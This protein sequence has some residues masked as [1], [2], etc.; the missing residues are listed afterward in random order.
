MKNKLYVLAA[1]AVSLLCTGCAET[2]IDQSD[3]DK[4]IATPL[5]GWS[6]WNA[7]RVDISEDIIKNQADLMVRTGLKDAGYTNVNIDDGFFDERDSTGIMKANAKRFPNGMKPV[8]D[9]IHGL[10]LKAG[11]YTDAGNNTCG[12]MSDKDRA[13]VG[14]GIYGHELQD[15]QLYFG[16]WGFDFIKIDY[17]GGSHLG[18]DEKERYTSI[19][20]S[21]DQV[22]KDVSVNICR[23]AFPRDMGGGCSVLM[24]YQWRYQRPLELFEVC[25]W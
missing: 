4:A 6:S 14:A 25:G 1:T 9:H 24:A 20:E 18:L 23:W 15:A 17:C 3:D 13:G 2:Q 22:N 19:R 8:V 7:F 21:I 5:M 12:S 16:D 10:G 11:I